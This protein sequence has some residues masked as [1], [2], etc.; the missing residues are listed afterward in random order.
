MTARAVDPPRSGRGTVLLVANNFPPVRGGSASV[1]ASLARCAGGR[2]AVLAPQ[3]NYADGLPIIGWR[4]HDR[5]A[6]YPV[7]RIP[8]LRTTF[9]PRSRGGVRRL[10]FL[11][12]DAALRLRVA[13]LL[14]RLI[15]LGGVRVVCIGELLASGW[16]IHLLR[17]V[18]GVRTVVYVHGEEITTRTAT[19]PGNRQGRQAL[20]NSDAIV[21]VSRFT[22]AAVEALLGECAAARIRLIENG[23]DNER[24]RPSPKPQA[25]LDLYGLQRHFVFVSVCRLVEKKG[26][27]H[28]IRAFA[29]VVR[30]HPDSRYLVVGT[31]PYLDALRALAEAEGVADRV[32]FAGQVAE[33][34]LVEHYQAG[35]VFIMPNRRMPDGD[36]E[37]FGLVFLEANGCGIPV[38]AGQDGGSTDAVQ[39]GVN[40]LVVDGH[41]VAEV[42]AAM[43]RL[44]EDPVL[45]ET[46]RQG[47]LAAAQRAG[48]GEKA[49]AFLQVCD[50]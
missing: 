26:I 35:D 30:F 1:Y 21:V 50:G 13:A 36:T 3:V 31:G 15:A 7:I 32:V 5:R 41:S 4:E 34:E 17:R 37:G 18:P 14:L 27:D 6:P 25:L 44:R 45:Y 11:A 23:V 9:G 19:D 42:A 48:W 10:L 49:R 40:G 28:A 43:R 20:Q 46:L 24:F 39:H 2:V 22:L 38:I 8:L 12:W 47:A 29:Q 33:D 16:I